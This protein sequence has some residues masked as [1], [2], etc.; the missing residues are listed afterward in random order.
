MKAAGF[1]D[2]YHIS[3]ELTAVEGFYAERSSIMA[4]CVDPLSLF[5]PLRSSDAL[6]EDDVS[7]AIIDCDHGASPAP[8]VRP[9]FKTIVKRDAVLTEFENYIRRFVKPAMMEAL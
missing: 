4:I 3:D 6:S 9:V 2:S 5:K 7:L 8:F 1:I